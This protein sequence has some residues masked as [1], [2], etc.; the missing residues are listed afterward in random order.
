MNKKRNIH[1]FVI[2][3]ITLLAPADSGV[4]AA[5][6]AQPV[7]STLPDH[8][9]RMFHL[10]PFAP[11]TDDIR[12][13]LLEAGKPGGILDAKDNLVAG[14]KNLIVDPSLSANNRNNPTQTAGTTFFGQFLDHDMSFDLTS[15]L[16]TTTPPI[17]SVNTRTPAFDLDSVYG[18]GP[19]GSP[20]LYDPNDPI[21]F[22]VETTGGLGLDEDLPR[23]PATMV[24][25]IADPRN[26]E[27]LNLAGLHAAF[28]LFHNKAVD[29]VRS[30]TPSISNQN[31]FAEARRLT[32]YHY[33]WMILYEYLPL[34]VGQA[35]VDDILTNGR[36]FYT[37]WDGQAFIP[38]E[39]QIA[40]RF[41]H[42]MVRPSYRANL[43]GDNGN[44]FF[45]MIFD[46][47][48]EGSPDPIDLRGFARAPRRYI[49]WQTFFDFGDGEV[50]PN[51]R[52]DTKISTPLFHLPL[53]TIPSNA[54]PTSLMQR[55]LLRHLTWSI[56]SGQTI[57][58]FMGVPVL[59]ASKFA[60]IAQIHSSFAISTP[61]L[62][63]ILREAEQPGVD[64]L[65]L[66]AV[67]GRIVGEV[68]I[69]LLESDPNSFLNADP[70][71]EPTLQANTGITNN[72]CHS[73]F[74]M[75]DFLSFAGVDPASRMP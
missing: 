58:R 8:F 48:G 43:A 38:V 20:Q 69:G 71:W 33:Q 22:R 14:P 47:A 31:A 4:I 45:G 53:P 32:T 37:P 64:G 21:K 46:P 73:K 59:K 13:A 49:D 68:F 51:K 56:P 12:A 11:P 66:G 15:T 16:G 1:I 19:A 67:G 10:P 6:N 18:E 17:T 7:D 36:W 75:T 44:A 55:N 63:Y 57:A 42:S 9:G 27:N 35:M 25:I 23:D 29:L 40:Y 24:A 62:F 74:C 28:L 61:L 70:F 34:I 26:D 39:F 60:D 72:F 54:P 30:T 52:I 65:H 2:L 3:F 5:T 50:K 41:G